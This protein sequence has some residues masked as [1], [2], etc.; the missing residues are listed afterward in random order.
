MGL[1]VVLDGVFVS[2]ELGTRKPEVAFY[3]KVQ[4]ALKLEPD[5]ILFWED[6]QENVKVAPECGWQARLFTPE[7][8]EQWFTAS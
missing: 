2:S 7:V 8:F 5:E 3:Q 4:N 1:E 6:N